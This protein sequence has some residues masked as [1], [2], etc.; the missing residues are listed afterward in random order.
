MKISDT[1]ELLPLA[2]AAKKYGMAQDSLKKYAQSG[3]L[4]AEKLGRN[5]FTTDKAVRTYLKNRL[6][7]RTLK[8]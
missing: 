3:K 8:R 5:W 1:R 2:V 7:K 6:I 4:E